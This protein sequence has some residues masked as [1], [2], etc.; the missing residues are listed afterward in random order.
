LSF[1]RP[2]LSLLLLAAASAL[3]LAACGSSSSGGPSAGKT[4][5][6]PIVIGEICSCSGSPAFASAYVPAL[7]GIEAWADT[8]NSSG[9]I[10]GHRID[11]ITKEDDFN[12]AQSLAAAQ[13]LISDKVVAIVDDTALEPAWQS[14]VIAADIPVVGP[15][16]DNSVF[17]QSPDFY[18][19]GETS[20]VDMLA[21]VSQAKAAKATKIGVM[22]C[23]ESPQCALFTGQI[24]SA[25][26]EL[27][28][29]TV[30]Y[31][32][33]VSATAP[34][35]IA[36]CVAARQAGVTA[37]FLASTSSVE[38]EIATNCQSQGFSPTYVTAATGA[39]LQTAHSSGFSRSWWT[40][41]TDIPFF[42]STPAVDAYDS[43]M[44]KLYPQ[45]RENDTALRNWVVG[46][47]ITAGLEAA[48][49][50][51]G[52]D[53][54]AALFTK[55]LDSLR[56]DTLD[57]MAPPLTF[58]AGEPHHVNCWFSVSVHNGTPQILNDGRVSCKS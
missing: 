33:S 32:A 40:T 27:G 47:L 5:A 31:S 51:S 41:F 50:P 30:P 15:F 6:A 1:R 7:D 38:D 54:T 10:D 14:A 20:L 21:V 3:V 23:A 52:T 56:N 44:N 12:A 26:T 4:T 29:V 36:Q 22:Y 28:G 9:G 24:K 46:K 53:P 13:Q 55:G 37:L 57:G 42:A 48:K 11:L 19:S 2:A 34:N 17:D 39:A 58:T 49:I 18:A 35:Y 8:V 45:Y 43:A 16:T 25:A